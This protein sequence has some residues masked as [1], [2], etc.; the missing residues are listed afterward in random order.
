MR[1]SKISFMEKNRYGYWVVYGVI[2]I[3]QYLYYTKKE[4]RARYMAEVA[5]TYDPFNK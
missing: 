4:A 5:K 2:G 1:R 3:R